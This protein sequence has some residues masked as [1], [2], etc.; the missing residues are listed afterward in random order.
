[1]CSRLGFRSWAG[2]GWSASDGLF[3]RHT[4]PLSDVADS[5]VDEAVVALREFVHDHGRPPTA[6]SWTKA[7]M[8]PSEKTVRR[9]FGSFDQRSFE[10]AS[11]VRAFEIE[12]QRITSH[13][14]IEAAGRGTVS[15]VLFLRIQRCHF[16]YRTTSNDKQRHDAAAY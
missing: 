14:G 6:D 9:L 15:R 1:M 3:E 4:V 8:R 16:E 13:T 12:R 11:R 10:M 5:R 2:G 7:S